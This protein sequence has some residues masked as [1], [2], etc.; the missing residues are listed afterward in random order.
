MDQGFI[1]FHSRDSFK[2]ISTALS[3]ND[4]P[5]NSCPGPFKNHTHLLQGISL[6]I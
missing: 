2:I 5:F 6:A 3:A 4:L 1:P